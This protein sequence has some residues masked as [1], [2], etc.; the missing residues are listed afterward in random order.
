MHF[1]ARLRID[2]QIGIF[3]II[4]Q[5]SD[6]PE[7][8]LQNCKSDMTTPLISKISDPDKHFEGHRQKSK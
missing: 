3:E 7:L 6:F 5:S 1:F 4:S 8:T 2:L